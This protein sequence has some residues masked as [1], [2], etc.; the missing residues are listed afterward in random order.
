M[1]NFFVVVFFVN[2]FGERFVVIV[3]YERCGYCVCD[4]WWKKNVIGICGGNFDYFVEEDYE[5]GELSLDVEIVKYM[6]YFIV[7]FLFYWS[8]FFF[9][10]K[11]CFRFIVFVYLYYFEF[12]L[13]FFKWRRFKVKVGVVL[14]V[15]KVVGKKFEWSDKESFLNCFVIFGSVCYN[16]LFFCW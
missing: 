6:F 3:V 5:I 2:F 15:C 10:N 11:L 12:F 7:N 13:F 4:L 8:F 9:L 1:L 16:L 14:F